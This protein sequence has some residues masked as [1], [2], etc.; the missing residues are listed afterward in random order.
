M[1]ESVDEH[2]ASQSGQTG[3]APVPEV[4]VAP[5]PAAA[6]QPL[7]A[8]PPSSPPA[9]VP[10]PPPP[11]PTA[12][13][14]PGAEAFAAFGAQG[15]AILGRLDPTGNRPTAIVGLIILALVFGSVTLNAALP[16]RAVAGPGTGQGPVPQPPPGGSIEFANGV[17]VYPQ[18]GWV[19][20]TPKQDSLRLQ[21]GGAILD[22]FVDATV[23]GDAAA[24]LSWYRDDVLRPAASQL[25]VSQAEV[26]SSAGG[27][28]G[29]RL[30]YAGNFNGVQQ[31][32]EGQVTVV[33]LGGRPLIFDGWAAQGQLASALTD[34]G[35]MVATAEIR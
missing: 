22:V 13:P 20:E 12:A 5:L 4:G 31:P 21:K 7:P 17:R 30:T 14:P 27:A 11:P 24:V 2:P 8:M 28:T 35:Q 10:P 16:S 3:G 19:P 9:L 6:G 32:L 34:I 25:A 33:I 1:G 23:Q 15:R 29:V 18:P 26:V